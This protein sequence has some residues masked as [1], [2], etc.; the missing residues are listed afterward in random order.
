[1]SSHNSNFVTRRSPRIA[2]LS[3]KREEENAKQTEEARSKYDSNPRF[4]EYI[5]KPECQ[6]CC[7]LVSYLTSDVRKATT[8]PERVERVKT[9]LRYILTTDRAQELIAVY[10]PI[11]VTVKKLLNKYIDRMPFN[12]ELKSI[13]LEYQRRCN[14]L[15]GKN[16][17]WGGYDDLMVLYK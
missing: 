6:A 3:A 17:V 14:K 10:P 13:S 1:M 8:V 4:L 9:L 15:I 12:T 16:F 7:T 2:A 11:R 5:A